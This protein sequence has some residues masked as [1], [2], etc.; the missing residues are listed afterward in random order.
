M[1]RL[2]RPYGQPPVPRQGCRDFRTVKKA[3][4][5]STG[6]LKVTVTASADGYYRW[7]YYGD[8]TT[9]VAAGAADCVDVR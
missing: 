9:G 5:S 8:S 1:R 7:V 4:T 3:T 2:Q 6:G